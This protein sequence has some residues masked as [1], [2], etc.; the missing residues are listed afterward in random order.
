ME[1]S[2]QPYTVSVRRAYVGETLAFPVG[3]QK[4][5]SR[6]YCLA[7]Y[8]EIHGRTLGIAA[9]AARDRN[10]VCIAASV[11]LTRLSNKERRW[12][13]SSTHD[14]PSELPKLVSMED[15]SDRTTHVSF[16]RRVDLETIIETVFVLF[17]GLA[18]RTTVE[19]GQKACKSNRL[20]DTARLLKLL[21]LIRQVAFQLGARQFMLDNAHVSLPARYPVTLPINK[22]I[23]VLPKHEGREDAIDR[24]TAFRGRRIVFTVR[25]EDGTLNRPTEVGRKSKGMRMCDLDG[26]VVLRE[27]WNV[28]PGVGYTLG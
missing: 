25:V 1:E 9:Q 28:W 5:M 4:N 6:F 7:R 16:F 10:D 2:V 26:S 17:I 20:V 22:Q 24:M 11:I 8:Q 12:M 23:L 21:R 3:E 14:E 27:R 18:R 15:G 19:V 13:D